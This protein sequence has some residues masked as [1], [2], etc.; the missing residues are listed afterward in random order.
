[1]STRASA[2][3]RHRAA[4]MLALLL[5]CSAGLAYLA[6]FG[7]PQAYLVINGAALAAALGWI[8]FGGFPQKLTVR[9]V[10]S[11]LLL[12]LMALPLMAGPSLNGVTR[13]ISIGGLSVHMGMA[14]IPL[15]ACLAAR[16]SDYAV[17]ILLSAIFITLVQPDAAS[18][19]A[20]TLAG[21]GLYFAWHDW[22]PGVVAIAGFAV[23]IVA[24]VRGELPAQPF[25]ERFLA[26]LILT[27][28]AVA[29][30]LA[31]SLLVSFFLLLRALPR[32]KAENYALAGTLAGFSIAALMS[33]YPHVLVGYGAAPIIGY[34]LALGTTVSGDDGH[35][36]H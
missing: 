3:F 15:L 28:P 11:L 36:D 10:L 8:A 21:V 27:N 26:N 19:F 13:W 7:A 30:S 1:M 22:K 12:A 14:V 2:W 16:D 35:A 31:L 29:L 9:R 24:S 32:G 18:A 4:A 34:G 20:L 23:G 5:P 6:A 25:V 33:N 17:P